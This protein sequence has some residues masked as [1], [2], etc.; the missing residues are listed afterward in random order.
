VK[1]TLLVAARGQTRER[2]ILIQRPAHRNVQ[3]LYAS[4]DSQHWE[5][6]PYGGAGDWKLERV[7]FMVDVD[8][9]AWDGLLPIQRRINVPTTRKHDAIQSVQERNRPR[10]SRKQGH[11]FSAGG[12]D[13]LDVG[14]EDHALIRTSIGTGNADSRPTTHGK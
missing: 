14:L 11:G 7:S 1:R 4:A 8:I 12:Q 5:I 10:G 6:A 13:G 3:R 9:E 2:D